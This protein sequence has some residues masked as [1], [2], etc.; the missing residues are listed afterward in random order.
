MTAE[1]IQMRPKPSS[2]DFERFWAAFPK[3]QKIGPARRQWLWALVATDNDSEL[4]IAAAQ[5]YAAYVKRMGIEEC[6]VAAP[7]NW[8]MDERWHDEYREEPK[9]ADPDQQ[10]KLQA[11]HIE[12]TGRS[13]MSVSDHQARIMVA[14]GWLSREKAMKAG[15]AV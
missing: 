5:R 14:K 2:A 8:L 13:M 3:K 15:Y 1:I 10:A 12:S 4:I 7:H 11:K 9:Q 6:F